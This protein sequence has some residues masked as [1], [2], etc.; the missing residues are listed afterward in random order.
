MWMERSWPGHRALLRRSADLGHAAPWRGP[1]GPGLSRSEFPTS[2]RST[3]SA[4]R[5]SS[6]RCTAAIV[7]SHPTDLARRVP[8]TA[9]TARTTAVPTAPSSASGRHLQRIDGVV[10]VTGSLAPIVAPVAAR[11][12]A[13]AVLAAELREVNGSF[14]GEIDG[15]PLAGRAQGGG[16][17]AALRR[18]H[19]FDPG[20]CSCVR[21]QPGR[22]ADAC[23]ASGMRRW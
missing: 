2:W 8:L 14:T 4:G 19:G 15:E 18:K 7:P 3:R 9:R 6:A 16:R 11:V 23:E 12:R 13:S 10:L 1:C 21:R 5:A 22:S 20:A 17:V